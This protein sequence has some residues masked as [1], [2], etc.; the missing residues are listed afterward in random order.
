MT[1]EEGILDKPREGSVAT[2]S[3]EEVLILARCSRCWNMYSFR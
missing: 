1:G 3:V 2:V